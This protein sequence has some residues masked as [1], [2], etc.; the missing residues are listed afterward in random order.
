LDQCTREAFPEGFAEA[1]RLRVCL[2]VLVEPRVPE[3]DL[4]AIDLLDQHGDRLSRC[5]ELL[6]AVRCEAR[7]PTAEDFEALF[8]R[9]VTTVPSATAAR[10]RRAAQART[11]AIAP[12]RAV[13]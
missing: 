5:P 6:A 2:L 4:E 13:R 12:S 8:V 1:K 7:S 9:R 3:V 10:G 11:A